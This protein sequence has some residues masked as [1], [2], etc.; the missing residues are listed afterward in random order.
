MKKNDHRS[1]WISHVFAMMMV[2]SI[3]AICSGCGAKTL[4]E[5]TDTE[6]GGSLRQEVSKYSVIQV[7][8]FGEK[9]ACPNGNNNCCHVCY[10]AYRNDPFSMTGVSYDS[11]NSHFECIPCEFD[12]KILTLNGFD[13]YYYKTEKVG[14]REYIVFSKE[15]LGY[16]KW[17]ID[18]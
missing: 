10:R 18:K 13:S 11:E 17:H 2:I 3:L 16:T 14:K 4:Y 15:F 9:Q 5:L 1:R 7:Y 8:F 12:D 6:H